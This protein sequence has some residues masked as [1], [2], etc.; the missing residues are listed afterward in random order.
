MSAVRA[1]HSAQL[2]AEL[3][4]CVAA[5]V[6][7]VNQKRDHIPPVVSSQTVTFPFEIAIR[8]CAAELSRAVDAGS[9]LRACKVTRAHSVMWSPVQ[10][11]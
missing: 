11:P 1:Q 8:G 9:R 2:L 3:E 5:I 10:A 7:A 6:S 4:E